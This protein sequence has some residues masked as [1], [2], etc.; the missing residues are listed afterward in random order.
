M[1]HIKAH[2]QDIFSVQR[3][4]DCA[5]SEKTTYIRFASSVKSEAFSQL[6]LGKS[7]S[8]Y[9]SQ[10]PEK[11]SYYRQ[12]DYPLSPHELNNH[13]DSFYGKKLSLI[14]HDP[15]EQLPFLHS[16]LSII[17]ESYLINLKTT[18]LYPTELAS[19]MSYVATICIQIDLDNGDGI[20]THYNTYLKSIQVAQDMED[21]HL[22]I[23]IGVSHATTDRDIQETIRLV[24]SINKFLP[25]RIQP[26]LSDELSGND[27]TRT[28]MESYQ[29]IMNAWIPNVTVEHPL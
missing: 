6:S 3:A 16:W 7:L 11:A 2:I 14:G 19:I 23:A 20:R 25:V 17:D 24:T 27:T 13:I 22:S 15:L 1:T 28:R 18:G 4:V 10:R 8:H 29:R 26:L 9:L 12:I 21:K 5:D